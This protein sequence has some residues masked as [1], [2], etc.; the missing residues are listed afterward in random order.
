MMR[1]PA[2]AGLLLLTTGAVFADNPCEAIGVAGTLRPAG[3]AQECI[4]GPNVAN[5]DG[6]PIRDLELLARI[7][8]NQKAE[9]TAM[10]AAIDKLTK[11]VEAL[12]ATSKSLVANDKKWQADTLN[13]TIAAV[14]KVPAKL[15][16]DKGLQDVLLAAIKDRLL[17]DPTF[18]E[19]VKKA[20]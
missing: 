14:D 18:L 2:I 20:P 10:T 13:S 6:R 4:T 9:I 3:G 19:A 1:I 15:A 16:A 5:G 8:N 17:K 12:E 7:I 11:A